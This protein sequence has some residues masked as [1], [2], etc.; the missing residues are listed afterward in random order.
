MMPPSGAAGRLAGVIVPDL[1][2]QK[3][4]HSFAIFGC[5]CDPL[6]MSMVLISTSAHLYKKHR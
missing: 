6:E 4:N 3:S 1:F 2:N 5:V